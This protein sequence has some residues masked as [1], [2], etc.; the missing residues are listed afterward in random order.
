MDA[1]AEASAMPLGL[2]ISGPAYCLPADSQTLLPD[3]EDLE[4][5]PPSHVVS[6]PL[7]D[8]VDVLLSGRQRF[9]AR[10][11]AQRLLIT[12]SG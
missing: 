11:T 9:E 7:L 8:P 5:L 6:E 4:P 1:F 10:S 3:P 2:F 12:I